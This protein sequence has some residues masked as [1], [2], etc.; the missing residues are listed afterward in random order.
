M[1]HLPQ[2]AR[3]PTYRRPARLLLALLAAL[4]VASA[5]AQSPPKFADRWLRIQQSPYFGQIPLFT[6]D[7]ASVTYMSG[8]EG[9]ET[10]IRTWTFDERGWPLSTE[11][12]LNPGPNAFEYTSVWSY[13]ADADVLEQIET[14]PQGQIRRVYAFNTDGSYHFTFYGQDEDGE[15]QATGTGSV[16][17]ENITLFTGSDTIT[18]TTTLQERDEAGNPTLAERVAVGAYNAV[19]PLRW[20]SEYR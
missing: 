2:P 18:N 9:K 7:V 5:A 13:D 12:A 1:Q 10:E 8:A 6:G 19:T 11:T 4:L 15:W 3:R 16:S 20:Q 17:A 14:F